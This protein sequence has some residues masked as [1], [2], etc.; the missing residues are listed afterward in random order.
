MKWIIT[1]SII[2]VEGWI[3][4]PFGEEGGGWW[5]VPPMIASDNVADGNRVVEEGSKEEEGSKGSDWGTHFFFFSFSWWF[6]F[7]IG[8]KE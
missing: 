2:D 6:W 4:S 5:E 3:A 8:R 7:W 1:E